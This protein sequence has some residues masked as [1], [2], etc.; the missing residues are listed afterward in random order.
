L[1]MGTEIAQI[2]QWYCNESLH[3]DLLKEP[4]HQMAQLYVKD[5]NMLYLSHAAFYEND[6]DRM[7]F[8]W[9]INNDAKGGIL[10]YLRHAKEKSILCF[11]HF[12]DKEKKNYSCKAPKARG[13]FKRI[14]KLFSSDEKKYGGKGISDAKI[15]P[16]KGEI[17]IDTSP[18]TTIVFEVEFEK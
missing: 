9:V 2:N 8:E 5:L 3:W 7:S 15:D 1:F 16:Q 11:H 17:S 10:V 18:F 12:M 4:L 14:T 6:F 13:K